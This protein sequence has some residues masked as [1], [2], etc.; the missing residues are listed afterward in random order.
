MP[1]ILMGRH[2]GRDMERPLITPD[3]IKH[4]TSWRS[5]GWLLLQIVP[6]QSAHT[7]EYQI[8]HA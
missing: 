3:L 8:S 7:V 5:T 2:K 6:N 1:T 4:H